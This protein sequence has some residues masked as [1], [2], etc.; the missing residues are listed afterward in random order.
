[1]SA[2]PEDVNGNEVVSLQDHWREMYAVISKFDEAIHRLK[3]DVRLRLYA[4]AKA[5]DPEFAASVK[6]A[7]ARVESGE[8]AKDTFTLA[9][10]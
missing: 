5:E 7:E 8:A 9:D 6:A 1:M 3:D 10:L 4:A 2:S